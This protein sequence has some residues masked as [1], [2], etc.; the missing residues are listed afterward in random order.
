[1][2]NEDIVGLLH[3]LNNPI[4]VCLGEVE[5]PADGYSRQ[6]TV[7]RQH[8]GEAPEVMVE[9]LKAD[10]GFF[11]E[12]GKLYI[13]SSKFS[14]YAVFYEDTLNPIPAPKAPETGDTMKSSFGVA[15]VNLSVAIIAIITAISLA[16]AAVVAKRK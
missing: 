16:G 11:I 8:A 7:L 12:N 3:Q 6:F 4:T 13:V 9:G 14:Q 1:M 2:V 5:G 15:S 10:G